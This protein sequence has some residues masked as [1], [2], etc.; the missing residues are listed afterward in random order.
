MSSQSKLTQ[1]LQLTG[2]FMGSLMDAYEAEL[3]AKEAAERPAWEAQLAARVQSEIEQ[4]LR[5]EDGELI[6]SEEAE[7]EP[8][9]GDDDDDDELE[10]GDWDGDWDSVEDEPADEDYGKA[11]DAYEATLARRG[12]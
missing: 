7:A 5:D 12:E 2:T 11:E 6:V 9:E 1:P 10:D 4:G 3:I 8:D